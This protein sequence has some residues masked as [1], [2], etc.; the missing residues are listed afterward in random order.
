V[1]L[2]FLSEQVQVL[3]TPGFFGIARFQSFLISS[4]GFVI[5]AEHL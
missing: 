4:F 1:L 5:K 2:R 3:C